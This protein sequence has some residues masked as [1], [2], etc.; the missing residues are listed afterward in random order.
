MRVVRVH[1][2]DSLARARVAARYSG[3]VPAVA[4]A[5]AVLR[6]HSEHAVACMLRGR[7]AG[8]RYADVTHRACR[9]RGIGWLAS[10]CRE[11]SNHTRQLQP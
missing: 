11:H 6:A 2:H 3:R 4:A 8:T 1:A 10:S 5:T 9:K 7:C